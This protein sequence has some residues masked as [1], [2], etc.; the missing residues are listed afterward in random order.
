MRKKISI[1]ALVFTLFLGMNSCEKKPSDTDVQTKATT[2]IK[3]FP[4]A[5]VEVMEGTAH[6]SGTF[7]DSASK[8]SA[9][10]ALKTVEGVK[11]VMDMTEVVSAET[12]SAVNPEILQKATDALKNFPSVKIEDINGELTLTGDVSQIQSKKIKEILDALK[13]GK[14]NNNLVVE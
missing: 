6:L 3:N 12:V 11:D 1:S 5:S 13:I 14:Y 2:V 7:S 9:I 8:D 10:A 4:D